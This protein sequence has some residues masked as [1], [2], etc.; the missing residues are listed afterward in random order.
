MVA[1]AAGVGVGA[2]GAAA[3]T[4]AAAAVAATVELYGLSLKVRVYAPPAAVVG[5]GANADEPSDGAVTAPRG[6]GLDSVELLM[7]KGA[8]VAQF[9][10]CAAAAHGLAVACARGDVRVWDYY[11]GK[12]YALLDGPEKLAQTLAESQITDN[13]DMLLETRAPA[14][15]PPPFALTKEGVHAGLP[16]VH[17]SE[18]GATGG[19]QSSYSG[20]TSYG[21]AS[22]GRYSGYG[23]QFTAENVVVS[24]APPPTL[25]V[26]GL[27]N[28]GNTCFMNSVVQC[29][30][31]TPPLARFIV[32]P[33]ELEADINR[34]NPLGHDGK[35]ADALAALL[36]TMWPR[37]VTALSRPLSRSQS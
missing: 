14:P 8:T 30:A 35:L 1:P 33:H 20:L 15:S 37:R 27:Q 16:D 17:G 11:S 18:D 5:G 4:A 24:T 2:H 7:S 12:L 6:A 32:A 22:G 3:G 36:R 21:G 19:A 29:L 10:D 28:L 23:A 31:H 9:R 13:N 34:D 25:G 26:V